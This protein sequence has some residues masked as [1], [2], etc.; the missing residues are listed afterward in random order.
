MHAARGAAA[1]RS[2]AVPARVYGYF[3]DGDAAAQAF[4]QSLWRQLIEV[5]GRGG[6]GILNPKP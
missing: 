6:E 3:E 5:C 4:E 2:S 1:G